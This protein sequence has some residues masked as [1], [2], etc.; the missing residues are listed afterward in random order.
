MKRIKKKRPVP[1]NL[2]FVFNSGSIRDLQNRSRTLSGNPTSSSSKIQI[3]LCFAPLLLGLFMVVKC[4]FTLL[5][6]L[7]S[8]RG[9]LILFGG[10]NSDGIGMDCLNVGME[11][12]TMS[13]ETYLLRPRYNEM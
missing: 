1:T 7:V 12:Y 8:G 6:S 3:L 13:S 5:H 11:R 2:K 9:E 4:V 10:M